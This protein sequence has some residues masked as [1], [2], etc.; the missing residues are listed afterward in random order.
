M[1]T[2][3]VK[4][5]E[6][7]KGVKVFTVDSIYQDE[8]RNQTVLHFAKDVPFS[9]LLKVSY[10]NKLELYKYSDDNHVGLRVNTDSIFWV[11]YN[12]NEK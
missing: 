3:H 2:V 1:V 11:R 10:E 5:N 4:L 6:S 12:D 7:A 8:N 9:E